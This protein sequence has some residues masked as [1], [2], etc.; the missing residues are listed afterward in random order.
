MLK[1]GYAQIWWCL[2]I[3]RNLTN[4]ISIVYWCVLH[5]MC[6]VIFSSNSR[7]L[8]CRGFNINQD[9]T[10]ISPAGV[11]R[12][13]RHWLRSGTKKP[14]IFVVFRMSS[15]EVLGLFHMFDVF[16]NGLSTIR[17]FF[18]GRAG[19][20]Q[21]QK[22]VYIVNE[23]DTYPVSPGLPRSLNFLGHHTILIT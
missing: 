1:R 6:L 4:C 3:L 14:A 11:S 19:L 10:G 13:F 15:P 8:D 21:I 16:P 12:H 2:I 5:F 22:V 17:F 18:S 23:F 20:K 9:I 7:C